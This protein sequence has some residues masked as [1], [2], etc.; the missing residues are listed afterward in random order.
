MFNVCE[1]WFQ[2]DPHRV[3]FVRADALAQMV[4]LANVHSG[5]R[6]IVVDDTGGLVLAAVLERLGG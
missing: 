4:T 2:K 6:F 5:R 3:R 1:Y